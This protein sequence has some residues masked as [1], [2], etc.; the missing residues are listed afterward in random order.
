[1]WVRRAGLCSG[2]KRNCHQLRSGEPKEDIRKINRE[3]AAY[4]IGTRILWRRLGSL[5]VPPSI[6]CHRCYEQVRPSVGSAHGLN[7]R[8]GT[9]LNG[10][11][12]SR[13]GSP[14]RNRA[15]HRA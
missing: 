5:A 10:L 3:H 2:P 7:H 15:V 9:V 11:A 13:S 1:M 6:C 4:A 12:T 8:D 14:R